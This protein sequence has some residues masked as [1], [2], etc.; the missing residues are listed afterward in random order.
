MGDILRRHRWFHHK[1]MS[2]KRVQK[3]RTDDMSINPDLVVLLIGWSKLSANQTYYPYLGSERSPVWNFCPHFLYVIMQGN[4]LWPGEM[5]SVF[6]GCYKKGWKWLDYMNVFL[7]VSITSILPLYNGTLLMAT[8]V[9]LSPRY[10][11]HFFSWAIH[12]LIKKNPLMLISYNFT[13][14]I[15]PLVRNLKKIFFFK[16]PVTL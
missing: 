13:P 11:G 10:Y 1:M 12:F 7:T 14:L 6:S 9:T 2:V 8:S 3:F 4:Q 15:W 5:S 16:L